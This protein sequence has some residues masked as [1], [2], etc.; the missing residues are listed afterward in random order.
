MKYN[1][2]LVSAADK[3]NSI[4]CLGLD[5]V[6]DKIPINDKDNYKKIL[7]FFTTILNEMIKTNTFPAAVKPNYAFY[8]QYGFEGLHALKEIIDL[9][10]KESIPVILDS[11]RGDIGNTSEAYAKETFDFFCADAVTLSPY[12][13]FD[14]LAPFIT[15]YPNKGYY[16]LCRTSNQS[17]KDFQ[18]LIIDGTP[19]YLKVA[20]KICD[21]NNSGIGAVIG[22]TYPEELDKIISLFNDKSKSI[23]IL[24]PGIGTQGGNISAIVPIL[25]KTKNIQEHRINSSSGILYAYKKNDSLTYEKAA[26]KELQTLNN[27][28]NSYL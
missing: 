4:V 7:N 5:P 6:I 13:G 21:W 20:D 2:Y 16:I 28:I 12:M 25:K 19:F 18:D 14:T 24:L 8:A 10:K 11:K 27:E 1:E 3:F 23:P 22:A 17:S 26:I 15:L 9:F